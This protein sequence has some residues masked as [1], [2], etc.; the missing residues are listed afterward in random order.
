[1]SDYFLENFQGDSE[2][3]E[4]LVWNEFDWQRYLNKNKRDVTKLAQF[5][6]TLKNKQVNSLE[7][8]C[9]FMG[10][11]ETDLFEVQD[12]E[13]EAF[14]EATPSFLQEESDEKAEC[15]EMDLYTIHKHPLHILSLAI[16]QFIQEQCEELLVSS[17]CTISAIELWR[18]STSFMTSQSNILLAIFSIDMGDNPLAICHLKHV[19]GAINEAFKVLN[20]MPSTLSPV[21]EI[22]KALFTF[23]EVLLRVINDCREYDNS[24]FGES[25]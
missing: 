11:A 15:E 5:Y 4:D 12:V 13:E 9:K 1:M 17:E 24:E 25:E 20:Q 23:R 10:W 22:V 7:E 8:I 21:K 14:S 6:K 16:Y 18:L 3:Q 19:L 2:D